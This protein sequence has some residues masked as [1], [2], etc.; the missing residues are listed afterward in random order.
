M[1]TTL[2]IFN[3]Q[4]SKVAKG[5][6]GKMILIYGNNS[7]GKTLQA[8]RMEKPYYFGFEM[9]LRAISGIPFLPINNWRDF[10]KINKA[11]TN[12][13]TLDKA[14]EMYQTLIFDEVHTAS[15]YCQEY[16][17]SNNGVGTIGEGN[18]GYG[19]WTEYE[20]E[21]FGELDKLMK[22]GFTLIFIGHEK[23]DKDSD[24]IV[25]KGDARSMTP[26]RD[27][28]DVVAYLTSNGIDENNVV[29]KSSA[30]F[31]ETSDFFA[32]S[33]FDY[34]DSYLEEFTAEN[35]EKAIET[36]IKR[37]EK[38]DGVSAV[39]YE[40]QSETFKSDK[41]DYNELKEEILGVC[42]ELHSQDRLPELQA[43][44]DEHLGQGVK[45]SECTP[46]QVQVMSIVLDELKEL[47]NK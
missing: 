23:F 8:T 20:N 42:S 24:K 18:N 39:T 21:F 25:P 14:K 1:T 31:A 36:A 11:M 37:Q 38:A 46:N 45:V 29:I 5:L 19:L 15:K 16:I 35:L 40:E 22:A 10:K 43:V 12:P 28:A 9:G 26:V 32:R 3:P 7:T 17:C 47:L 6:E 33:R 13:K 44:V 2:D 34:I 41:L 30:W 27:N 4:I